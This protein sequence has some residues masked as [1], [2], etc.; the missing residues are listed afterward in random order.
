MDILILILIITFIATVTRSTFGFGDALLA[1]PLLALFLSMQITVPLVAMIGLTISITITFNEWRDIQ[2]R[3]ILPMTIASMVGIPI[4][5]FLI[6]YTNESYTK[7]FMAVGLLAFSLYKLTNPN[8]IK[9]STDRLAPVFGFAGGILGGAYNTNGPAIVIYGTLRQWE[10]T[11]FR[12]NLQAYF[13]PAGIM[14]CGS[15]FLSGMWTTQVITNYFSTLPIIAIGIFLGSK[16]NKRIPKGKF[17]QLIYLFLILISG[18][19]LFK[20][21]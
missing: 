18:L 3:G 10:P 16:I 13:L 2:L 15:H 7:S 6:K 21:V 20:N 9:I 5:I 19:L 14:I 12:T 11:R 17:D 1:M 8:M 4:G